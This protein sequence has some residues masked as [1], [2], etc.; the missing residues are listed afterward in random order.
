MLVPSQIIAIFNAAGFDPARLVS[1][2][3]ILS[4]GA[5]LHREYKDRLNRLLPHRFYELYGLTEGFIT[6]LDRDDA[7]RKAGSVGVPP[8]FYDLRIVGDDGMTCRPVKPARSSPRPDHD[9]GLLRPADLTAGALR[10]GWLYTGDL[11]YVD[12]DGFLYL[13][14]RKKDMIDSG[15]IKVYPRDIEEIAA[16]IRPCARSPS[17]E[18]RTTSGA[19]RPPVQWCCASGKALRPKI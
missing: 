11:G 19:K 12:A 5:P 17:S 7:Q 14:D 15:G 16:R 8:P 13:V 4:L 18:S 3:M 1:L 9:A 2:Q 10:D 6:V